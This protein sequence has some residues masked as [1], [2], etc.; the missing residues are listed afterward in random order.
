MRKIV[1]MIGSVLLCAFF[2]LVIMCASFTAFE[3][4]SAYS[5]HKEILSMPYEQTAMGNLY[6]D[7]GVDKEDSMDRVLAVLDKIPAGLAQIIRNEWL[8]VISKTSPVPS[9]FVDQELLRGT[10]YHGSGLLWLHP[11][12]TEE[13]LAH[14]CGHIL[15]RVCGDA[16]ALDKFSDIYRQQWSQYRHYNQELLNPHAVSDASEFFA[17][18]FSDYICY[19]EH[20]KETLPEG[21]AYMQELSSGR[22]KYQFA[23]RCCGLFVLLGTGVADAFEAC[24][25]YL[26][27]Q[28]SDNDLDDGIQNRPL[29]DPDEYTPR[30]TLSE[31][32]EIVQE[33]ARLVFDVVHDPDAYPEDICIELSEHVDRRE[34]YDAI[35]YLNIYFGVFDNNMVGIEAAMDQTTPSK[36][37]LS[38]AA[39]LQY[40]SIRE[41]SI[42]NVERVLA[43]MHEGTETEKLLQIA[44]YISEHSHYDA[45]ITDPSTND[46]WNDKRGSCCSFAFV[47]KQFADRLGIQCD[48]IVSPTSNGIT[49]SFNRVTL[50]DGTV[51]YYDLSRPDDYINVPSMDL[52]DFSVNEFV[53]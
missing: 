35:G 22:W 24:G 42:Q 27:P 8:I 47:F 13:D 50:S 30:D 45:F 23:G 26:F 46:F 44:N 49:H 6:V 32:P 36:L 48:F 20:L 17:T 52:I 16:S 39:I 14:E 1:S 9:E 11:E 28:A 18:I 43:S 29:I 53:H 4:I 10:V 31:E 7:H 34:Y 3:K 38:K 5:A 19:P 15:D 41:Y 2:S 21:Y 12:F 40:H 33:I 25:E 37:R 51:R